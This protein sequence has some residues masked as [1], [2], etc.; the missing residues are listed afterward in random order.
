MT[1]CDIRFCRGP[2]GGE[3]GRRQRKFTHFPAANPPLR[4]QS[5]GKYGIIEYIPRELPVQPGFPHRRTFGTTGLA[6]EKGGA[7]MA[8]TRQ[9]LILG[10]GGFGTQLAELLLQSGRYDGAVFL[11]DNAPGC[12]GRLADLD[13]TD[14]LAACPDAFA[15]VGSNPFRLELLRRLSGAGY[16]LPVFVHPAAVVAPSAALGPGT[17]VLPFCFVGAAVR[18]GQGCILNA[19][20]IID[21]NAVLGDGVHA[22]PGAIVKAGAA[23]E[24]C[25]KVESGQIIRS[26]WDR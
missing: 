20:A 7:A 24:A 10:K 13:R 22:A 11:D 16:R 5:G 15:A 17:V 3:E 2:G 4:P 26:P 19:G 8:A 21:H 6:A 9:V 18:T 23:V 12:A 14:L 1:Y 25:T